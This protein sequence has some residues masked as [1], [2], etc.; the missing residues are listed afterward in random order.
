MESVDDVQHVVVHGYRRAYRVRGSGPA[1][2]MLHGLGCDSSTWADVIPTLAEH[3]TVIAPEPEVRVSPTS[4]TPTTRSAA[5]P[6]AC[7]T[8]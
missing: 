1:L 5:T 6:T 4:P 3:Y 7:A 2:L 8:C